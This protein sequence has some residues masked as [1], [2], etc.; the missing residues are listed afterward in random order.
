MGLLESIA[1]RYS[2]QSFFWSLS[3]DNEQTLGIL[4]L[5]IKTY[6]PPPWHTKVDSIQEW[7]GTDFNITS[8]EAVAILG[9][10]SVFGM[11]AI[12]TTLLLMGKA[13]GI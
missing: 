10:S 13:V 3:V 2:N 8:V 7:P 1:S 6:R 4:N 11:K 9:M 5:A 12:A